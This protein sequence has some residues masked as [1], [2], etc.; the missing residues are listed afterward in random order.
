MTA[1]LAV[2]M[3]DPA[4]VGPE[5][6]LA[7]WQALRSGG[8]TF[9]V[10]G[11]PSLYGS[12]GRIIRQPADAAEC[13]AEHVPV[14]PVQLS[15][16]CQ[17]GQPDAAHAAAIL[18]S[19]EQ[20]VELTASGLASGIVTNPIAKSVLYDAGFR[21]PGHTEFLAMI[22]Q[23]LPVAGDRGPVMMLAGEK[24]RVS[25][26][27]I[28]QP[29]RD[30][31][32][33]LSEA[34]I[35]HTAR[36]TAQALIRDFGIKNPRLAI[37]GLNPHAGENGA[38]GRE[39]IDIVAPAL[40]RLRSEGLTVTGPMSPDAMFH[41][42][43]RSGYDAAIC[44]YHDQGLIPFKALDFWGGVNVTLGL[45]VIRTSPDHGTGFDIA[46]KGVARADS[47]IAAIRMA[48]DMAARRA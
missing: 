7:A 15:R 47:L 36:V 27:S 2:T 32:S 12:H 37:A 4:G 26:V 48:A 19:I 46:G 29:L 33:G 41:E 30:A 18:G 43:A 10:L 8:P 24:L 17:P 34:A 14:L 3:G 9:F 5:I 31:I 13:F 11:D 23:N 20:A 35:I 45:P 28:H 22:T 39:E 6:T 44:L 16:T 1:P 40:E 42:E 25:L 38:L 21:H